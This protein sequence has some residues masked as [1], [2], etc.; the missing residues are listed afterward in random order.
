MLNRAP[1]R[2]GS[3]V[4]PASFC[5]ALRW[6]ST[7]QLPFGRFPGYDTEA[8]DVEEL[9]MKNFKP[10]G[11]QEPREPGYGV[12]PR[13]PEDKG[14]PDDVAYMLP[15]LR[16]GHFGDHDFDIKTWLK[17]GAPKW[18]SKLDDPVWMVARFQHSGHHFI[19]ER[20]KYGEELLGYRRLHLRAEDRMTA[21]Q[22]W[23]QQKLDERFID[24]GQKSAM[25]L[26]SLGW[27]VALIFLSWFLGGFKN[28]FTAEKE[29]LEYLPVTEYFTRLTD[30]TRGVDP[31]KC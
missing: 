20:N 22:K 5:L 9:T 11:R 28:H 25:I 16:A 1:L 29:P 19:K 31:R 17:N 10:R 8:P 26:I 21:F 2:I 13:R 6:R 3:G 23:F 14:L 18:W 7:S 24:F 27:P 12:W 15:G 30:S 4:K